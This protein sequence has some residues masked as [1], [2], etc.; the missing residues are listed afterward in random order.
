VVSVPTTG[1]VPPSVD[2]G[3]AFIVSDPMKW[4]IVGCPCRCGENLWLNLM[5]HADPKWK[6]VLRNGK[7][8]VRP[9]VDAV[10]CGSHFWITDSVIQWV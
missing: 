10:E 2:P 4:L 8:G 5:E 9:S 1:D 3:D 7:L 6:V